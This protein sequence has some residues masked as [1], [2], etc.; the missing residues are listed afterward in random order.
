M[1]LIGETRFEKNPKVRDFFDS[2][3]GTTLAVSN[4]ARIEIVYYTYLEVSIKELTRIGREK[5]EPIEIFDLNLDS[6]VLP[7]IKILGILCP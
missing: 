6:P 5:E 2:T 3:R 4:S 7:E 1:S